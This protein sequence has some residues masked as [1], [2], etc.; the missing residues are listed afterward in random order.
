MKL[1]YSLTQLNGSTINFLQK[2]HTRL[3][4]QVDKT[5]KIPVK[6]WV[7][8]KNQLHILSKLFVFPFHFF[9]NERTIF[10]QIAI[11]IL[12]KSKWVNYITMYY[13]LKIVCHEQNCIFSRNDKNNF[14]FNMAMVNSF[15][16]TYILNYYEFS[17]RSAVTS[18]II[19]CQV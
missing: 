9:R 5:G 16:S 15:A 3:C 19:G 10:L 17:R 2:A 6:R 11:D 4:L 18:A 7:F 1:A 14:P 12:I 13:Y 8:I